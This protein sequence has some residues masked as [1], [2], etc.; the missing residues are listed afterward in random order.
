MATSSDREQRYEYKTVKL[1]RAP[2]EDT[3]EFLNEYAEDGWRAFE[4]L[5]VDGTLWGFVL[6]RPK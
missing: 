1:P 5:Q 4:S 2:V 6:E 3:D